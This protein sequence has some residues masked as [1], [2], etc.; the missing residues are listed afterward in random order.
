MANAFVYSSSHIVSVRNLVGRNEMDMTK[1]WEIS[2]CF[3]Y[4]SRSNARTRTYRKKLIFN[5]ML[6]IF[7]FC[8]IFTRNWEFNHASERADR[9]RWD[10]QL[11]GLS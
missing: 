6:T 11:A 10:N 4:G 2:F 5:E 3:R 8:F 9:N 7:K 1:F